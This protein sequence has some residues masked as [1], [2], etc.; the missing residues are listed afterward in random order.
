MKRVNFDE[1][2]IKEL[3]K[4]FIETKINS[5]FYNQFSSSNSVEKNSLKL[6]GSTIEEICEI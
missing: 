1:N 3:I 2:K 4:Y 6:I 5:Q